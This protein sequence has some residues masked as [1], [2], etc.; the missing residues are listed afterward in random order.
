ME[1]HWEVL[2]EVRVPLVYQYITMWMAWRPAVW[3]CAHLGVAERSHP[4]HGGALMTC[5]GMQLARGQWHPKRWPQQVAAS[6]ERSNSLPQKLC[7]LLTVRSV[8]NF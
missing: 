8:G 1:D 6:D 2:D 7:W 4:A 5:T 3:P